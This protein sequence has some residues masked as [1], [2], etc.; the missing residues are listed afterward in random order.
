MREE[1]QR[2]ME[3][4]L[5]LARLG[6]P[7]AGHKPAVG[8]VIVNRGRVVGIG[9]YRGPGTRHAEREAVQMAGPHAR[10]AT[11]F[12]TLEPHQYHG[13]EPPCT[14]AI[15][16]AG[17]RRVVV[18]TLDPNP[19]VNGKGIEVLKKAGIEVEVGLMA[20]EAEAVNPGHHKAHRTGLPYIILKLALNPDGTMPS[21]RVTGPEAIRFVH[22]LRGEVCAVLVGAGTVRADDP[23]LTPREVYAPLKPLRIVVSGRGELSPEARVF[24]A[25]AKTLLVLG[26]EAPSQ[27]EEAVK[28]K[29]HLVWRWEGPRVNWEGL[30]RRLWEELKVN[31]ILVE[32]GAEVAEA[33]LEEGL[34][35]EAALIYS[36][37]V[38]EGP[39]FKGEFRG[40]RVVE[41]MALGKD[42]LV[43]MRRAK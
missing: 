14:D 8:A 13:T 21:R 35:D 16:E 1:E 41:A 27:L 30:L 42:A 12:V 43:R 2:W 10:G 20:A 17:I 40:F 19:K 24:N 28:N 26:S 23:L 39:R 38:G 32:G 33:L 4:A 31:Y 18:A 36:A 9:Y 37:E 3:L 25:D 29:G 5:Q 7:F 6:R 11:M 15:I 22:R 34:V